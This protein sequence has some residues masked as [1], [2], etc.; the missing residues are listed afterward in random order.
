MSLLVMKQGLQIADLSFPIITEAVLESS[1]ETPTDTLKIILPKYRN[2]QKDQIQQGDVVEWK[3]GYNKYGMGIEFKGYVV[4]VSST[5]PLV[6]TAR[7]EMW[8]CQQKRMKRNSYRSIATLLSDAGIVKSK[9]EVADRIKITGTYNRSARYALWKL[10]DKYSYNLFFRNG[11]F[12]IEESFKDSLKNLSSEV[13]IDKNKI[14]IG[15]DIPVFV[16]S[17][18][19]ISHSLVPRLNRE[20]K[21]TIRSESIKTGRMT[22]ASYGKGEEIFFDID[23]LNYKQALDKAKKLYIEKCGEGFNGSLTTFGYPSVQHSQIIRVYDE[24]DPSFSARAYVNAVNKTF[25]Q[26]GFRQ[27]I[28]PGAFYEIPKPTR[29]KIVKKKIENNEKLYNPNEPGA[30]SG[31]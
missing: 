2:L 30:G 8:K 13:S 5:L 20:F 6:I 18:N 7:D 4:D 27:E 10:R 26:N 28:F 25:T 21:I 19:I 17:Y 31:F 9:I 23:D 14:K 24:K 29:R 12:Y 16:F 15:G 3:A 22:K 11:V 1:R